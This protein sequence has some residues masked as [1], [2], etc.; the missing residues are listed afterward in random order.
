[1]QRTVFT[2]P[3][4]LEKNHAFYTFLCSSPGLC[5]IC[6]MMAS[7]L[8]PLHIVVSSP[9]TVL[10]SIR[11]AFALSRFLFS[12]LGW[13]CILRQKGV[14]SVALFILIVWLSFPSH[15]YSLFLVFFSSSLH[16]PNTSLPPMSSHVGLSLCFSRPRL[17]LLVPSHITI[18]PKSSSL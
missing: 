14:R 6:I 17:V 1:M 18:D 3:S 16:D 8:F 12:V 9:S 7:S 15:T 5:T 13:T 4:F 11:T 10:Y 2:T